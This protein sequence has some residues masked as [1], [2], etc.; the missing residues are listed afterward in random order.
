MGDSENDIEAGNRAGCRKS[1]MVANGLL[2]CVEEMKKE[3][4]LEECASLKKQEYFKFDNF[5]FI[6]KFFLKDKLSNNVYKDSFL[7]IRNELVELLDDESFPENENDFYNFFC[8]KYLKLTEL[9][10]KIFFT[11]IKSAI[12]DLQIC[13]ENISLCR[14]KIDEVNKKEKDNNYKIAR[15]EYYKK[16]YIQKKESIIYY[17]SNSAL[18]G[19][20]YIKKIGNLVLESRVK[21]LKAEDIED[22]NE[23]FNKFLDIPIPELESIKDIYITNISQF[24]LLISDYIKTG[25]ILEKIIE[26]VENNHILIEKKS[27]FEKIINYYQNSDFFAFNSLVP[28]F[29]EGLFNSMCIELGATNNELKVASLNYKLNYI[30]THV[31]SFFEYEYF[32]FSFP[33][34]RNKIAHGNLELEENRYLSNMLILDLYSV[35][36][37]FSESKD[38]PF[39]KSRKKI[40]EYKK[41]NE[42]EFF[43]LYIDNP[44]ILNIGINK[45]YQEYKILNDFKSSIRSEN[46]LD[47]LEKNDNLNTKNIRKI[48]INLKKEGFDSIRINNLLRKYKK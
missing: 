47:F 5:L 21:K 17:I 20:N 25:K 28:L 24:K 29:I 10:I 46:F 18:L 7:L 2:E 32:A 44:S 36:R 37:F 23:V 19:K 30:N 15:L 13:D 31:D 38:L 27:L 4:F 40:E 8:K 16:K 33:I 45:F 39:Y 1:F 12:L 3:N 14:T 35:T 48:L 9:P 11:N 22:V 6:A 42:N 41:L 26:N 43:K 34:L